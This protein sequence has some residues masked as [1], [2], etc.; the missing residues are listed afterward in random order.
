MQPFLK[1]AGGKEKELKY[2]V[3]ALPGDYVDYY[4][5]FVGGGSVFAAMQ[6]RHSYINDLS[7]ELTSFY[8]AIAAR[9]ADFFR[10][11]R[12]ID[13]AWRGADRFFDRCPELAD[14][15][16]RY[17]RDSMS[18]ERLGA[19]I[20]ALCEARRDEI[21]DILS[22]E[23]RLEPKTLVD[24]LARNLKRKLARM[25]KLEHKKHA[26][27]D[28]DIND[29]LRTAVK[30]ALYMY[31]RR[32]Y[33]DRGVMVRMSRLHQ[34][35]FLFI[36]NYC[37][38]GMFRY[39]GDGNFNVPYGGIAYNSKSLSGKLDYYESD[40]VAARMVRTDICNLDFEEFFREH[41]PQAD[42]FVFLDPPYDS[43]FSTYA[44]NEFNRADHERLANYLLNRCSARWM[45]VIKNTDFIFNLYNHP[46]INIRRFN[47]EYLVSFM[48]RN[49]RSAI[50]LLITN[51]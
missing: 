46:G 8:C 45:L 30:S 35:L 50:H 18:D 5:P 17:R 51:Y 2:I 37:Y 3:P 16:G 22:P 15:Y 20:N 38:S 47:K 19:E 24:E 31:F 4:E 14:L 42:D 40:E 25:K 39:N 11:A 12:L 28:D 33:N 43:E 32:L 10:Y 36:R 26:L 49:D 29:N 34:A 9:D 7:V 1:W 27:P 13:E 41:E 44:G 23:L 6:A 21:V 48:N